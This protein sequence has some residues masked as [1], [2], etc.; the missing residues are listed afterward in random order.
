MFPAAQGL[1]G[2][3]GPMQ[4]GFFSSLGTTPHWFGASYTRKRDYA[5]PAQKGQADASS[6]LVPSLFVNFY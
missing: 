4:S 5:R 3:A 6:L 2:P 1:A